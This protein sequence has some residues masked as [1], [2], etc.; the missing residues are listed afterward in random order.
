[1]L[2]N[3]LEWVLV[4]LNYVYMLAGVVFAFTIAKTHPIWCAIII[5]G[6]IAFFRGL[7]GL[8]VKLEAYETKERVSKLD[9]IMDEVLKN[10][11]AKKS[12]N[13]RDKEE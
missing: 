4:A 8:G 13:R 6:A 1:M 2:K 3:F 12:K 7:M 11:V 5:M 10:G 9:K